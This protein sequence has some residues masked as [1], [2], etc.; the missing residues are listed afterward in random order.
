MLLLDLRKKEEE[1]GVDYRLANV[2]QLM[3]MTTLS[4]S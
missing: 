2:S 3:I 1:L 4:I